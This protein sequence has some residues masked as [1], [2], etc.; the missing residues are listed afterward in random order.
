MNPEHDYLDL[1]RKTWNDKVAVHVNSE[2]YGQQDFLNGKNSLQAIEIELLG[3][4]ADKRILHLQCHFGQDT[5]SLARMGATTV[6]VDFSDKAIEVAGDL[7]KTL[8]ADA[9][10]ICSDIYDLPNRMYQE[11]DIVFT[12]YGTIGWLPD[13]EQWAKVISH[14][15]KPGGK[16]VF[17]EFH[18]VIWMFDDDFTKVTYDYFKS[19]PIIEDTTGTYA[20]TDSDIQNRTVSW[21]HGVSEVVKSLIDNGLTIQKFD[22]YDYSP[23]NCFRHTEE[24]EP[25]KFRIARFGNKIPMVYAIVAAKP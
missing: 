20:Q 5:I 25:G 8:K 17:V 24:F 11:F 21:N 4:V 19:D 18:P 10:F 13:L 9:T 15:L 1:N 22:E 14:F 23:Y 2:F 16:F 12:S 3:D 6:G 7:A